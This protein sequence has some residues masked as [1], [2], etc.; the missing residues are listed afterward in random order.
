MHVGF[1]CSAFPVTVVGYQIDYSVR[2]NCYYCQTLFSF[3]CNTDLVV[4]KY[5]WIGIVGEAV[6]GYDMTGYLG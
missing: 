1:V 5:Y 6:G 2:S 3:V 4:G